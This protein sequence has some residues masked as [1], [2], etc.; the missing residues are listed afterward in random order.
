MLTGEDNEAEGGTEDVERERERERERES[1][2]SGNALFCEED[3]D[4][5]AVR[6]LTVVCDEFRAYG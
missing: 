1:F 3:L 2:S 6:D 4:L 5:R